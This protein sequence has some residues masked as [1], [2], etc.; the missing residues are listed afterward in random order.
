M[1]LDA[2]SDSTFVTSGISQKLNLQ[3]KTQ[4]ISF[5]NGLSNK[6]TFN[7]KLVDF[8]IS[9]ITSP[10]SVHVKNAWIVDSVKLPSQRINTDKLTNCYKHFAGIQFTP[11]DKSSEISVLI[12]ADN[13]MLHMHTDVRVGKEN[14]PV[15][16]KT[17]L[18][19]VIFVGNKNSKMLSV[20]A[21]STECNLDKMVSKFW[22]IESYGV[23]GKQSSSI[24]P[25]IEQQTLNILQEIIVNKN[26]RYTDGLL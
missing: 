13:P 4:Q 20:N 7:S 24:M 9:S 22:E 3:G 1:L 18:G 26:S 21:F 23:S 15:A 10:T 2:G 17:K 6:G 19:W 25:E 16:L 8:E 12:G 5:C 11:F 14:E